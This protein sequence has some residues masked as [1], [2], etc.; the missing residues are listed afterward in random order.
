MTGPVTSIQPEKARQAYLRAAVLAPGRKLLPRQFPP[1]AIASWALAVAEVEKR[2]RGGLLVRAP[3]SALI[4]VDAGPL[5][6]ARLVE[7]AMMLTVSIAYAGVPRDVG[8]RLL[9]R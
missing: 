3:S 6:A 5:K 8:L 7:P 9:E 4:S 2:Q 1:L